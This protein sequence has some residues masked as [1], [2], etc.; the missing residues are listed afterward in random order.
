[1]EADIKIAIASEHAGFELKEKIKKYLIEKGYYIADIGAGSDEPIDYPFIAAE[2]AER[3]SKGEFNKGILL[4][5]TGIGMTM[6]AG[7]VPGIRAALCTNSFMAK[8][9]RE[10]NNANVLCLGAW[11]TGLKLSFAIVDAFLESE[12]TGG[13]H[14]RRVN[15]IRELENKYNSKLGG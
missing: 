6:A 15:L 4:C 11:I 2:L 12:F 10:H 1:M 3:V 7:K 14:E 8:M 9:T 13:R 5:G